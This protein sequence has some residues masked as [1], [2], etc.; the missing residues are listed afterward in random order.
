MKELLLS[1]AG[2]AG[3]ITSIILRGYVTSKLW[4]W[5]VVSTFGANPLGIAQSIGLSLLV[6]YGTHQHDQYEDKESTAYQKMAKS[7]GFSLFYPLIV[8]LV[9]YITKSW[10]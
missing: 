4:L 6:A 7:I 10:I 8:L 9:G 2:I 1:T 3:I 5:F